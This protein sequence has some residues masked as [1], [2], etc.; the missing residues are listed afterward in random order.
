[1]NE[2]WNQIWAGPLSGYRVALLLLNRGPSRNSITALWDDI[3][4]PANSIVE[5]TDLWEVYIHTYINAYIFNCI[6]IHTNTKKYVI[7]VF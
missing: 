2:E 7:S 4:I 6:Y 1:M 5:A 3:E